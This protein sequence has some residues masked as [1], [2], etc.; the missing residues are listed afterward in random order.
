MLLK[1]VI[2]FK[3]YLFSYLFLQW[4][5]TSFAEQFHFEQNNMRSKKLIYFFFFSNKVIDFLWKNIKTIFKMLCFKLC[6]EGSFNN[7]QSL[8]MLQL[9]ISFNL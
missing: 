3:M 6:Q 4:Q 2:F 8:S 1:S 7:E 9:K 5:E